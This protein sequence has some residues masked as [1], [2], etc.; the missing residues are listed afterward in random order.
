M[1]TTIVGNNAIDKNVISNFC[2][3]FIIIPFVC[4]QFEN[5]REKRRAMILRSEGG[6]MKMDS[7]NFTLLH[8]DN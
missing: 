7:I 8:T 2:L 1:A 6:F 5:C 4:I 3:R